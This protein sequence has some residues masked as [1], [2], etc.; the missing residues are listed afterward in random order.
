MSAQRT[1][2][3][4]RAAIVEALHS[5]RQTRDYAA[6]L[7]GRQ[8]TVVSVL[9]NGA[10]ALLELDGGPDEAPGGVRRWSV[11]WDDLEL[12]RGAV[13]QEQDEGHRLGV[14]GAGRDVICHAVPADSANG[15]CGERAGPLPTLGWSMPFVPMARRACPKCVSELKQLP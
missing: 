13:Q 9:R 8:G 4:C 10:L 15:L 2:V 11:H 5:P 7:I 14:S 3:G 6:F 1:W 12:I